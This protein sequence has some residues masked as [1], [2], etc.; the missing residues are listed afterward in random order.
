LLTRVRRRDFITA[1]VILCGA[2][3]F[4]WAEFRPAQARKHCHLEAEEF[5]C[6]AVEARQKHPE[7]LLG[8]A[9]QRKEDYDLYERVYKE[10]MR[11]HGIKE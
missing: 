6:S 5:M 8:D 3:W 9:D 1:V 11:R 2:G 4:Y 10:C 7:F